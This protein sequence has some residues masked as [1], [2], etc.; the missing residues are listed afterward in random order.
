MGEKRGGELSTTSLNMHNLRHSKPP[1]IVVVRIEVEDTGFGIPPKEMEQSKL[2]C[3]SPSPLPPP[4][5][6]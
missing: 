5:P 1:E 3:T 2:F 4:S 6:P